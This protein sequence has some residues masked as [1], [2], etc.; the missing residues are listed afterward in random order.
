MYKLEDAIIIGITGRVGKTSVAYL[1]HEYLKEIG[2]RSILYSSAKIDSPSI[3]Q[4]AAAGMEFSYRN[5]QHLVDI[6]HEAI[7]YEA[8]YIVIE[9]WEQ[10]ILADL[11]KAIPFDI[12]VLTKYFHTGNGHRGADMVYDNKLQFFKD[13]EDAICIMNVVNYDPLNKSQVANLVRDANPSNLVLM[14]S[15]RIP[16]MTGKA[17]YENY[18]NTADIYADHRANFSAS[19]VKYHLNSYTE[20]AQGSDININLNG[21]DV[22]LT[23]DLVS[24]YHIENI[25]T[26]AVIL[27]EAN[28]FDEELFKQFISDPDLEI[29]GRLESIQW[30]GRTI[31]IDNLADFTLNAVNKFKGDSAVKAVI[32]Y[33]VVESLFTEEFRSAHPDR[34]VQDGLQGWD[35]EPM[36]INELADYAYIT[37]GGLGRYTAEDL[38]NTFA[39]KTTIPHEIILDRKNAIEKALRDSQEGDII[40]IL[41]R[42][43]EGVFLRSYETI[44]IFTDRELV[45]VAIRTIEG[46]ET[47]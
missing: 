46:E 32:G 1:T 16:G 9:C 38:T 13:E 35:R 34:R 39:S 47:I 26:T 18:F 11:F 14:D 4:S 21:H 27:N 17:D 29:P 15:V 25:L 12:K 41:R 45:D 44:E 23:T 42:G 24:G 5:V 36:I 2:K 40:C 6:L 43:G 10:S 22:Q 19:D 30:N 20:R 33:K 3:E 31:L 37:V 28:A 8:E 7:A